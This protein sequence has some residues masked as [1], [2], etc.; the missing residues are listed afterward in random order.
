MNF[1]IIH[2][3][4]GGYYEW[5]FIERIA[6]LQIET[7]IFGFRD[8]SEYLDISVTICNKVNEIRGTSDYIIY[9]P[10]PLPLESNENLRSELNIPDNYHVF[11]RIGR[12]AN[13]DPIAIESINIVKKDGI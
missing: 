3:A 10:I 5:P 13:F 2:F 8:S 12:K 9:N 11:G 6:T 7:N 4:R 1:D